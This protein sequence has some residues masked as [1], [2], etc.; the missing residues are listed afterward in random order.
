M[1]G[2]CL[3][4]ALNSWCC[5]G[6]GICCKHTEL[7]FE[8][9]RYESLESNSVYDSLSMMI[10]IST[11]YFQQFAARGFLHWNQKRCRASG[12]LR[13]GLTLNDTIPKDAAAMV[14]DLKR[15][16]C[17]PVML[18]GDTESAGRSAP[19]RVWFF[20]SLL[21]LW[22]FSYKKSRTDL[23]RVLGLLQF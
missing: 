9:C 17:Q 19:R 14:K 20:R 23:P 3:K 8:A 12:V 2:G 16:G 22:M 13:L 18:T 21:L 5:V 15:L 6:F 4:H 7:F 10:R 1:V 11:W